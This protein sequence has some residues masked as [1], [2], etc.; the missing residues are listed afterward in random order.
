MFFKIIVFVFKVIKR[1]KN[2]IYF[3]CDDFKK[4][5]MYFFRY[6]WLIRKYE[7]LIKKKNISDIDSCLLWQVSAGYYF[8]KEYNKAIDLLQKLISKE[9]TYIKDSDISYSKVYSLL[10]QCNHDIGNSEYAK[11]LL[12]D[13]LQRENLSDILKF[14]TCQQLAIICRESSDLENAFKNLFR[15]IPFLENLLIQNYDCLFRFFNLLM[16]LFYDDNKKDLANKIYY[17][18]NALKR[19][20]L[21]LK[22]LKFLVQETFEIAEE[23]GKKELY[24][25][26]L[27]LYKKI[28]ETKNFK[29][30]KDFYYS[31]ADAY[32]G[33]GNYR[34]AKK[35][36]TLGLKF[37][38][39]MNND[40]NYY[41][42]MA[43]VLTAYEKYKQSII[44]LE[45]LLKV[46]NLCHNEIY[47]AL[48]LN[49]FQAGEKEKTKE[50][51]GK[52]NINDLNEAQQEVIKKIQSE[53]N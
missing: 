17:F 34:N 49:N 6:K 24:G 48:I 40:F 3:F 12:N 19:K 22:K 15:I 42:L 31:I 38:R 27:I 8:H 1:I 29:P 51:L 2:R 39:N 53:I 47:Y 30:N 28:S 25:I 33:T 4:N 9:D 14:A 10:A 18:R 35:Y 11:K 21:S 16:I 36:I 43:L 46:P 44:I 20:N 37:K 41:W 45:R 7:K 5:F 52:L 23:S 13:I 50:Y 26:V 32:Y